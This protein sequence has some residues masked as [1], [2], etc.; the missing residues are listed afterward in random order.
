MGRVTW[1]R[2]APPANGRGADDGDGL[3]G[4]VRRGGPVAS[5]PIALLNRRN[6]ALW[7]RLGAGT[8]AE[9]AAAPRL[10]A[11]AAAV[12][13][14]LAGRGAS[15][16]GELAEVTGLLPTQVEAAL[17]EL[18]AQGLVTAD[19]FA[20][21]RALLT[22]ARKRP[23]PAPTRGRV[24]IAAYSTEGAGRWALVR[25]S[26]APGPGDA[27]AA[28]DEAAVR[29]RAAEA[30]EAYAWVLLRRYG[31][32]VRRLLE[33]EG[34]APHW[35]DLLRVFRRL[36]ARGEI[37]GGRFVAGMAG[38]QFALPE[39]VGSL[40]EARRQTRTG[41]LVSLSAA[42]PLNLVGILTPGR[43]IPALAGNRVLYRDGVPVAAL[44][45]GEARYLLDVPP[46]EQWLLRNALL[47]GAGRQAAVYAP[48]AFR[49][50]G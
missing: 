33:R 17:G 35:R 2:L 3:P 37:R 12:R 5:T 26:A 7:Q 42:D 36:E 15:F 25:A 14:C 29:A 28:A 4:R 21:L 19:S 46:S 8:E 16:F 27:A 41:A 13:E 38:E 11:Q 48:P 24:G 18:V 9:P 47:G 40:R 44:E 50:P 10:S 39:A 30:L 20:G 43:R 32:V 6:L 45:G 34:P 31:V 23:S 1:A 49:Q 22:P